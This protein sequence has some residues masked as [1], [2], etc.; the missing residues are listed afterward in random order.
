MNSVY[1]VT[2]LLKRFGIFVYTKDRLADLEMM[3]E[4]IKELYRMQMIEVKEYQLAL[5]L[6]RQEQSKYKQ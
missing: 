2:Q 1:D 4:E 5:L 6:L 3:E